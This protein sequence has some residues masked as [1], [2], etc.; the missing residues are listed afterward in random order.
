MYIVLVLVNKGTITEGVFSPLLFMD[1]NGKTYP[2]FDAVP[3]ALRGLL[4][5]VIRESSSAVINIDKVFV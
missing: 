2:L 3:I 5:F 1:S 4:G